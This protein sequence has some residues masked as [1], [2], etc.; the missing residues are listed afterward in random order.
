MQNNIFCWV[1][2]ILSCLAVN[3]TPPVKTRSQST[4]QYKNGNKGDGMIIFSTQYIHQECDGKTCLGL[5]R[6]H[7]ILKKYD[8]WI[9]KEK[10]IQSLG[11]YKYINNGLG[12]YYN[13]THLLNDFNHL[14]EYHDSIFNHIYEYFSG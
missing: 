3:G 13:N 12:E 10:K 14:I 9:S 4:V 11:M 1:N 8:L 2:L 5:E 7:Y 6:V